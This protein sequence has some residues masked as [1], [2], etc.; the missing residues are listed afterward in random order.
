MTYFSYFDKIFSYYKSF[1]FFIYLPNE[2]ETI[3][4]L[5]QPLFIDFRKDVKFLKK[6]GLYIHI[7]FCIKKCNYCDFYS[8]ACITDVMEKY[9][10]DT[11]KALGFWKAKISSDTIID[12]IYFGGGTPSVLGDNLIL[13]LLT[14]IYSIYN[15]DTNPEITLEVNP[16]SIL[17][18]NLC[19]L[20]YNGLNRISMGLQSSNDDELNILGRLHTQHDALR[21]VDHIHSSGI[22]NFSLDVMTGIPLQTFDS[23]SKTLDFCF[24]SG[25]SHISTYLLK[26]EENTPFY[27]YKNNYSFADD[28]QQADFYEFTAQKLTDNGF[29]HYEISNFCKN[30]L[31]SRHNTKY[32]LLEDYLGLGPSAHSMIDGKRFYYPRSIDEY[33]AENIIFESVG[34]TPEEYIMLSLRTDF[35]FDFNTYK[36][37]FGLIPSE[38]FT[39]ELA[40]LSNAGLILYTKNGFRLTSKGFLL[41]NTIISMLLESE[42]L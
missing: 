27:I 41:S 5:P 34:K 1:L 2:A 22:S 25:A 35:G 10:D 40:K 18:L 32:W 36:N 6:L 7:P 3:G 19:T 24:D 16:N 15:V 14:A 8:V 26:I 30:N 33:N 12:T 38:K 20:K 11:I 23:L 21:A 28:E 42:N 17:N 13:K 9:V 39:N 29:R 4:F 37:E 31:I